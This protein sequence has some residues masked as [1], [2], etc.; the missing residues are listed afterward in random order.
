ALD[1]RHLPMLNIAQREAGVEVELV[2]DEAQ[3]RHEGSRCLHCWINTIFDSR[4]M[5]GSEC[6]Q[7]GG[8]AD[9]CPVDCIDLRSIRNAVNDDGSEQPLRMCDGGALAIAAHPDAPA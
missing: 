7:C 2:L 1:R 6:I 3:A 9:V 8:C 5:S 4:A